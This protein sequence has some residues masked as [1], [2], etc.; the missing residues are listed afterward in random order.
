M[1]KFKRRTELPDSIAQ[2][3]VGENFRT[4]SVSDIRLL[5]RSRTEAAI[6][7]LVMIM[8]RE[9]A[10]AFARVAAAKELLDRG[11]GKPVQPL[12]T[13]QGPLELIHRIERVIVHPD[14]SSTPIRQIENAPTLEAPPIASR[15][16]ELRR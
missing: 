8:F 14:H 11:W 4:P 7:V 9:T 12:A 1:T 5:A 10:H 13:D 15:A 2:N 3:V 16:E 6:N